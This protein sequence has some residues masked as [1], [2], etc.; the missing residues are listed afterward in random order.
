MAILFAKVMSPSGLTIF[1]ANAL[2]DQNKNKIVKALH[3]ADM[4][5]IM[6][7]IL[8]VSVAK[9][10]KNLPISWK[11]G[12]PGGWPTSNLYAVLMYSPQSQKLTVGSIVA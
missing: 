11:N 1:F 8:A 10:L 9:R 3:S 7:A 4:I 5:F 2:T 12:A 6:K